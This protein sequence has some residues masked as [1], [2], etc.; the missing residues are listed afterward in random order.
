M[1]DSSGIRN[2]LFQGKHSRQDMVTPYTFS[3]GNEL[4]YLTA[5]DMVRPDCLNGFVGD[6]SLNIFSASASWSHSSIRHVKSLSRGE[7]I[8]IISLARSLGQH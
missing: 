3:I 7:N 5:Q 2:L 1:D 8:F 4:E 6:L